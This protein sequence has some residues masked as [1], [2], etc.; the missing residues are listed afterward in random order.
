MLTGNFFL[1]SSIILSNEILGAWAS[2]VGARY[3]QDFKIWHFPMDFLA[4]KLFS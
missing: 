1:F 2:E 3:P 4:K